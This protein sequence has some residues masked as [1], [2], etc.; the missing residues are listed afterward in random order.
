[1]NKII[2]IL[3]LSA[4]AASAQI[5]ITGNAAFVGAAGFSLAGGG[6]GGSPH[7]TTTLV[8]TEDV[9]DGNWSFSSGTSSF[10]LID[11]GTAPW[12][13]SDYLYRSHDGSATAN[14]TRCATT[15]GSIDA[16][17]VNVAAQSAANTL[18]VRVSQD[19]STWSGAQTV[20]VTTEAL[21]TVNFT[22]LG[23]SSPSFIY[24]ELI[25]TGATTWNNILV[26]AVDFDVNP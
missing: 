8:P 22:S 15:G 12:S 5:G 19:G 3:L 26:F 14:V 17:T 21:Y 7:A 4:V 6:G 9:S 18:Q 16:I 25:P 13:N 1:M 23:W 24:V 20:A 2:S 10:A 11:E